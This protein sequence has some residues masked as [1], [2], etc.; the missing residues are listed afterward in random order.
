MSFKIGL[1]W[2][3]KGKNLYLLYDSFVSEGGWQFY[4]ADEKRT[5]PKVGKL[6]FDNEIQKILNLTDKK[7]NN[8]KW[9]IR[10]KLKSTTEAQ[11]GIS[12]RGV[13]QISNRR[14]D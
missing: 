9:F 3:L 11:L 5:L 4:T 1:S 7:Q 13:N 2:I 6:N 8:F 14:T 12:F 10:M